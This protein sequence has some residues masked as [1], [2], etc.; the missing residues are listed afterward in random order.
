MVQI[1]PQQELFNE[2]YNLSSG[3]IDTYDYLPGDVDYPFAFVGEQQTVDDPNKS[4]VFGNVIQ[5]VH[6]YGLATKRFSLVNA[7]NDL[8]AQCRRLSTTTNFGVYVVN[9]NEQVMPDNSTNTKL[10]HGILDIEFRFN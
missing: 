3:V 10:N 2:I 4:A 9:I 5:T 6:F 7:M 8:K 1:N